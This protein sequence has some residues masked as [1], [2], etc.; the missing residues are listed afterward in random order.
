MLSF[1]QFIEE[2]K[3]HP[4]WVKGAAIGLTMKLSDLE[5]QIRSSKD[6]VKQNILIARQNKLIGYMNGLGLAI[7]TNDKSLMGRM[8]GR[9]R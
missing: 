4:M 8:R 3:S 5:K 6:P 1:R 2:R 7:D 9:K